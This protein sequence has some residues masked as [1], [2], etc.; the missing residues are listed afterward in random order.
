MAHFLPPEHVRQV[1]KLEWPKGVL[2]RK[3]HLWAP[4]RNLRE[5][6]ENSQGSWHRML[7]LKFTY[8]TWQ[9]P[10]KVHVEPLKSSPCTCREEWHLYYHV[11]LIINVVSVYSSI[12]CMCWTIKSVP[13]PVNMG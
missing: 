12:D 6:Q 13:V 1:N 10:S 4:C 5:P 11:S 3:L 9:V 7:K 8:P 2:Y